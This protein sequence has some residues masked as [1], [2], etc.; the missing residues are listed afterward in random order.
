MV[1]ARGPQGDMQEL[2][3]AYLAKEKEYSS[4][5]GSSTNASWIKDA[6]KSPPHFTFPNPEEANKFFKAQSQRNKFLAIDVI[7]DE[8][9]GSYKISIPPGD[10][11]EGKMDAT[12]IKELQSQFKNPGF[13]RKS[14]TDALMSKDEGKIRALIGIVSDA[15]L[16]GG[17]A[18]SAKD[19]AASLRA[20]GA[21]LGTSPDSVQGRPDGEASGDLKMHQKVL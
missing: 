7:G 12:L 6:E 11:V 17:S 2:R 16:Q 5:A 15:T 20:V 21:A 13:D 10:M 9:T 1:E 4:P 14:A 19:K 18:E 3:N 8:P